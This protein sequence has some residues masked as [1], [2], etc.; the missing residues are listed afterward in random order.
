MKKDKLD[1]FQHFNAVF[2]VIFSIFYCSSN[3]YLGVMVRTLICVAAL[4]FLYYPDIV[5]IPNVSD[6]EKRNS[7][8]FSIPVGWAFVTFGFGLVTGSSLLKTVSIALF[9]ISLV[10]F[11]LSVRKWRKNSIYKE[12]DMT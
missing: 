2:I 3:F 1:V 4:F 8:R 7:K 9:V 5:T 6:K 10:F 12:N 11:A